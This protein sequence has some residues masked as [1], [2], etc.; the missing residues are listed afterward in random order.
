M[1]K[2]LSIIGIFVLVLLI[3][4]CG[5]S[6]SKYLEEISYK[7][8][9]ELVENKETFILEIY[10]DGCQHCAV[11]TP[12]YK[13][14]LN[15][16]K[17]HSKAINFTKITEKE[18]N[19]FCEKYGK[20]IGTPTVMFFVDG[21]EKTKINRLSGEPSEKEIIRKLKQNGYIEEE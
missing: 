17:V 16:Y 7:E 8:L 12:R 13:K 21:E 3:S 15:E 14:V 11:F 9:L 10:Q 18:Y 1:K 2:V 6:S 4:G 5:S 19:E 20:G